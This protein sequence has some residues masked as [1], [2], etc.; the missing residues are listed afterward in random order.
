MFHDALVQP[1]N[2]FAGD[3]FTHSCPVA[4]LQS[5]YLVFNYSSPKT[6]NS[7]AFP[8]L[9]GS[10]EM[11]SVQ[12][13]STSR[14]LTCLSSRRNL[15]RCSVSTIEASRQYPKESSNNAPS[16]ASS[17]Q[18]HEDLKT[19]HSIPIAGM[20]VPPQQDRAWLGD[21]L[22]VSAI[23]RASLPCKLY[24]LK[25]LFLKSLL[26]EITSWQ[27]KSVYIVMAT[28]IADISH[29]FALKTKF[30]AL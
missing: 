23:G 10:H 15:K 17:L 11:S 18:D 16:Q 21:E 25:L 12:A 19:L 13:E 7:G 1:A 8:G 3:I 14:A 30:P 24:Q 20:S 2:L 5:V 28:W 6:N 29:L 22:Q 27:W 9:L 4:N 26:L